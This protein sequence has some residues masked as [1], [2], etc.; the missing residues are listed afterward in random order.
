MYSNR[1]DP[2]FR[3]ILADAEAARRSRPSLKFVPEPTGAVQGRWVQRG[4][5]RANVETLRFASF[6]RMMGAVISDEG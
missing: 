4:T 5:P 3:R 2:M 6:P 1:A